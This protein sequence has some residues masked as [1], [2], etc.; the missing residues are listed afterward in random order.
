VDDTDRVHTRIGYDHTANDLIPKMQGAVDHW[1][2][3]LR[4]TGGVLVPSKSHWYLVDFGG[5][6]GHGGI[7][8]PQTTLESSLCSTIQAIAFLWNE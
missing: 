8:R 6:M 4:A 5:R 3:G 7:A 1:E 2:G